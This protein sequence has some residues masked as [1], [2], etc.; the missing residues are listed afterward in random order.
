MSKLF[1]IL[2]F[3]IFTIASFS[4]SIDSTKGR[5]WGYGKIWADSLTGWHDS[6]GGSWHAES[7]SEKVIDFQFLSSFPGGILE[8]SGLFY[9]DTVKFFKGSLRLNSWFPYA[10]FDTLWSD[11]ALPIKIDAWTT[12]TML[13]LGGKRKHFTILEQNINLLK[14]KRLMTNGYGVGA[15]IRTNFT[16]EAIKW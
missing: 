10:R 7:D 8:D 13:V 14:I 16:I 3:S 5:I 6:S 15:G 2:L 11:Y 1:S 9:I 12:D 4:Q